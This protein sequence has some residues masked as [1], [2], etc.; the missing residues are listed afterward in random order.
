VADETYF[1]SHRINLLVDVTKVEAAE[2]ATAQTMNANTLA[3]P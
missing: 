3:T 1:F 2:V